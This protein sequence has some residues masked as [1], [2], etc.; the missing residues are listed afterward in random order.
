M[1]YA[2]N[3]KDVSDHERREIA[4]LIRDEQTY[5]VTLDEKVVQVCDTKKGDS[6]YHCI[7]CFEKV[8]RWNREDRVSFHHDEDKGCM[9]SDQELSGIKNPIAATTTCPDTGQDA[10]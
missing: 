4:R 5:L 8:H 10:L 2:L 6:R 7:Y 1:I 9:G 3:T